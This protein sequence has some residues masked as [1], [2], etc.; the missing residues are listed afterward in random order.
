MIFISRSARYVAICIVKINRQRR[1]IFDFVVSGVVCKTTSRRASEITNG[2]CYRV[3]ILTYIPL[4][5]VSLCENNFHGDF[6]KQSLAFA[7]Y[8]DL[9]TTDLKRCCV[10][11][12][13]LIKLNN[14]EMDQIA[15]REIVLVRQTQIKPNKREREKLVF[16]Q[17]LYFYNLFKLTKE[18]NF[19]SQ[20]VI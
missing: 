11:Q 13:F 20:K 17:T 1:P 8:G 9:K 12:L 15:V 6:Q 4:V 2:A 7:N 5:N 10:L 18:R 16:S 19:L 3:W 14:K